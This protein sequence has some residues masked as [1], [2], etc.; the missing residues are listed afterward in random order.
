MRAWLD[1]RCMYQYEMEKTSQMDSK[2]LEPTA[3]GTPWLDARC[4]IGPKNTNRNPQLPGYYLYAEWQ[5]M[6]TVG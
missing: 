4:L 2:A 3:Q 1:A 6:L 5:Q